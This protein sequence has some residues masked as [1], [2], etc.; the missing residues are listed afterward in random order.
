MTKTGQILINKV[1]GEKVKYL[2]TAEDTNGRLTRFEI[3]VSPKGNVPVR[4][5]HPTQSETIEI[6]SGVLK[7]EWDGNIKYMQAGEKLTIEKGTPHQWWNDSDSQE[8]QAIFTIEPAN[9]FQEMQEQIFGIFNAKGKLSFLQIMVMAK[10]YDM[11]IAGPPLIIQKIMR[12]VLSP[13]GR[14]LGYKKYYPEY[15]NSGKHNPS[16]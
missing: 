10:K 16:R 5:I 1:T 11:V 14:I 3:W 2:Q 13:I 7:V 15:S 12:V 6:S 8:V 9:N 4:H